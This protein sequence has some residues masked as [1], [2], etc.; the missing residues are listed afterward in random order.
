MDD[1]DILFEDDLEGDF[2]DLVIR[3]WPRDMFILSATAMLGD[4]WPEDGELIL[5][6]HA[7]ELLDVFIS[8]YKNPES[9]G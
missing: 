5:K 3:N 4:S 2:I 9:E 7:P 1:L 6:E 8:N